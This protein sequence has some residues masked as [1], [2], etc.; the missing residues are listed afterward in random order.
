MTRLPG[1]LVALVVTVAL[2][3]SGCTSTP[4]R[5]RETGAAPAPSGPSCLPVPAS[6]GPA[7]LVSGPVSPPAVP[8]SPATGAGEPVPDLALP[9]FV[10]GQPVRLA[11]LGTPAVIN[12]W[13]SWCQPCLTE[14]P[15]IQRYA[16]RAAGRVQ[17]VGVITSDPVRG[18]P[19]SVIDEFRLRFPMLYDDK[20]TLQSRMGARLLPMT[21]LVDAQGRVVYRYQSRPLDEAALADLVQRHLGVTA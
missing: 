12:L 8:I 5:D 2:L 1:A 13:A 11:H 9:C 16:D 14:L 7:G 6:A 19:Q 15:Q 4:A 18:K 17:V 21:L 10:G 3:L 20:A